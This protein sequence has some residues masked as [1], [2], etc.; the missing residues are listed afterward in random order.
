MKQLC[1]SLLILFAMHVQPALPQLIFEKAEYKSRREKMMD[2]IPDGIAIIRGASMPVGSAHFHQ[3]NNMMYFAGV[4]I[5]DVI[6]VMDG[7]KQESTLFFT[8]TERAADAEAI[9][10]DLVRDPVAETGIEHYFP[11]EDFSS[12]LTNRLL[13]RPV[14]YTPFHSE[15][16]IGD[17]SVEK[18]RKIERSITQDEWDGRLS[19]EMQ[20][21]QKLN[22]RFTDIEVKNCSPDIRALRKIKSP[23]EIKIM[24][25][26]ARVG[27]KAHKVVMEATRPGQPEKALAALFEYICM[28]DVAQGLAFNTIIMSDEH[29]AYGHYSQYDRILEEGDFIILDAGP[30][31]HYYDTDISTTFPA[32]GMF[33][34]KQREIYEFA[35]DIRQVCLDNY[36]PGITLADVGTE[37]KKMFVEKGY[38]VEN[39]RNS[40]YFRT[41]GFN[42][43]IGMAV[44]DRMDGFSTTTE[45][46]QVGFVFACD[47]MAYVDSVTTVRIEDTVVITPDG[48]EVLSAGLPR[49]V[50][51]I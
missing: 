4:D 9:P 42:H 20:F 15:E 17:N 27:V 1:L 32:N 37:I 12:T 44:H 3:Y 10:L 24:R 21:V 29:H 5:P 16:G 2:R 51:E 7:I 38:D 36:R 25:E 46:L 45:P 35:Y 48:C 11:M 18:F 26:A 49:S 50:E 6:L 39:P 30:D 41:G 34:E 8:I 23:A 33:S 43:S 14:V 22:E 28:V 47:I 13:E 31:V 40:R 19:R